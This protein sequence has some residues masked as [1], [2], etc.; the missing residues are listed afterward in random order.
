MSALDAMVAQ[1]QVRL[2]VCE[3]CGRLYCRAPQAGPYCTA[4]EVELLDFPTQGSRK[5]RGR[6]AR[7]RPGANRPEF[8]SKPLVGEFE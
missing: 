8:I 5:L 3:L 2:K 6:P 4:C 1:H 7:V